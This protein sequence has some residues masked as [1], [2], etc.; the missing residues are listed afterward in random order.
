MKLLVVQSL[1]KEGFDILSDRDS[2]IKAIKPGIASVCINYYDGIKIY[3][4][5][6]LTGGNPKEEVIWEGEL[7]TEK[8]FRAILK[9]RLT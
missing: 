5:K 4:I 9:T 2:V 1:I 7:K 3:R 6:D 8:D